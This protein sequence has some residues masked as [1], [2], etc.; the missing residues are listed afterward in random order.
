MKW[1]NPLKL[2]AIQ[3]ITGSRNAQLASFKRQT[4]LALAVPVSIDFLQSFAI[5]N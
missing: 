1:P 2:E 4:L 5:P 3:R